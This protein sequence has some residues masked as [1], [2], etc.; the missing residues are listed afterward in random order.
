MNAT[1][2]PLKIREGAYYRTRGGE[3]VGPLAI[4][5]TNDGYF[6][7]T[8]QFTWNVKGKYVSGL[9]SEYDLVKEAFVSD[10]PTTE[11]DALKAENEKLRASRKWNI[12]RDGEDLLIC[13]GDHEKHEACVAQ[14]WVKADTLKAENARLREALRLAIE[15]VEF[16]AAYA[17]PYFQEKHDLAKDLQKLRAALGETQ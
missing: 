2:T 1:H 9:E 14:R 8:Q 11:R 3:V 12:E 16:W 7:V 6:F 4:W 5:N 10:V 17:S 13:E 15:A